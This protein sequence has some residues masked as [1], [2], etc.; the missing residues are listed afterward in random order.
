MSTLW[1]IRTVQRKGDSEQ[2]DF[3]EVRRFT[4]YLVA[5]AIVNEG[6]KAL[7]GFKP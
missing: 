2:G 4:F 1:D 6:T 5:A 7:R 3:S